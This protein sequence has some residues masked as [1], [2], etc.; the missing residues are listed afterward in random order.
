MNRRWITLMDTDD[1]YED[2]NPEG[3]LKLFEAESN[4][5]TNRRRLS[6]DPEILTAVQ[7]L[8]E[9]LPPGYGREDARALV[10]MAVDKVFK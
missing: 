7:I 5:P 6:G 9:M 4:S 2:D 10:Y 3:V 8:L 1:Q